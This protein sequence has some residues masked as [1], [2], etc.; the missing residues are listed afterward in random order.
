MK[1]T[2]LA[3]LALALA[4]GCRSYTVSQV[5]SFIDD[6]GNMLR[7]EYGSLKKP[8]KYFIVSP[9]NGNKVECESKLMVRVHL[10]EDECVPCYFGQNDFANGTMYTSEGGEWKYYTTGLECAVFHFESEKNDYLLVYEGLA[11]GNVD[12]KPGTNPGAKR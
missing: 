10:P 4:A 9:M 11:C 1:F 12:G 6:D 8:H 5:D 3:V 2:P 7:V